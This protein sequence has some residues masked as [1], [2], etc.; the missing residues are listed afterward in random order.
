MHTYG[1]VKIMPPHQATRGK[2]DLH[3]SAS[4]QLGYASKG[5]HELIVIFGRA[6]QTYFLEKYAQTWTMNTMRKHN[7]P[8][9]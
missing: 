9:I 6:A 7:D 8:A 4:S 5:T 3:V 2:E 1:T